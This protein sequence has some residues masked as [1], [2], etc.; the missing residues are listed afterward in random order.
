MHPL[1][2]VNWAGWSEHFPLDYTF[3]MYQET[4]FY[5]VLGLKNTGVLKRLVKEFKND[6]A[7]GL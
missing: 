5:K 6:L 3:T 1:T 7:E 2:T 4:M